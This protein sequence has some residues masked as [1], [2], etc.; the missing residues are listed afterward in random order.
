MKQP[1]VRILVMA[2]CSVMAWACGAGNMPG[3]GSA[4]GTLEVHPAEATLTVLGG[5]PAIQPFTAL[6][7]H[8][9]GTAE[10][11]T[12]RTRFALAEVRLGRFDG[13]MLEAGGLRG[14]EGT[15]EARFEGLS[16]TARVT[17]HVTHVR[18]AAATPPDA[19]ALLAA[20]TEEPALVPT[21]E[22]PAAGTVV[23][24]NLGDFEVH[25]TAPRDADLFEVAITARHATVRVYLAPAPGSKAP[26]AGSWATLLPEEWR[27]LQRS[28]RGEPLAI[29]VRGMHIDRPDRAGTAETVTVRIT[30]EDVRGGIYYWAA[31]ASNGAGGIYRHDMGRAGE[32]A[33]QF[34]TAEQT[35]QGRCVGCHVL[36]RDGTR[37]AVTYD[38]GNRSAT[39]LDVATRAELLPLDTY[40]WNFATFTPDGAHLL[41]TYDGALRLRDASTGEVVGRVD[42]VGYGTHPDFS[43]AGDAIVFVEVDARGADRD[44]SFAGG[45]I[46]TASF[47]P[48]TKTFGTPT[49]L[50]LTEAE[51]VDNN[52]YPSWSPDGQWIIFN[53]AR[54]N[55]YDASSATLWVVAAD[56]SMPPRRLDAPDIGP[57]LT[58]AWARWAPFEQ[59]LSSGQEQEP[60]LWL[61]FSSKRDFGLRLVGASRPQIWM[62]PF[63]PARALRG[64]SPSAPAFRLPI[65]SLETSNHIAQWTERVV[66]I[67][68]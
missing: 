50:P 39:I 29:T 64:E 8:E 4:G 31:R 9:D 47:D 57:G 27:L 68:E 7:R 15:V 25:W 43:P 24:P 66:S 2:A 38:G 44:W 45:R 16:A 59:T 52:F 36:S 37:M 30:D 46:V 34:Y 56:G 35:P 20:A 54:G 10:D 63:F 67:I 49:P 62:A 19:P 18:V 40:Y 48:R 14:G 11:V 32:A 61:T 65:Q 23:P 6:L 55:A 5:E 42:G 17:V 1:F 33:E 12:A 26:R 60:L 53:R 22:Y 28:S 21:I 58:N 13:A 41:T 3:D 51:G